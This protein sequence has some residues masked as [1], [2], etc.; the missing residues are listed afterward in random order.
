MLFSPAFAPGAASEHRC[1][2]RPSGLQISTD[3]PAR[4]GA[5]RVSLGGGGAQ[6]SWTHTARRPCQGWHSDCQ[7][8]HFHNRP[9]CGFGPRECT[10]GLG[11]HAPGKALEGRCGPEGTYMARR[12]LRWG[13][14]TQDLF[15]QKGPWGLKFQAWDPITLAKA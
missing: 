1:L 6:S 3:T 10:S 14:L 9:W 15:T 11:S 2:C 12:G 4:A 5:A 7:D 8:P 13:A